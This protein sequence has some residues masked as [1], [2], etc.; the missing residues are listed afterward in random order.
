MKATLL[1]F[2]ALGATAAACAL[3]P[4]ILPGTVISGFSPDN[5]VAVSEYYGSVFIF[6]LAQ[7][8]ADPKIYTESAD[9][10][11]S[12]TTG[13]GNF[14]SNNY[15]CGHRGAGGSS[16][17]R[18]GAA[19]PLNGRWVSVNGAQ[20]NDYG[21]GL[22]NG[23]TADSHRFCGS[24]ATGVQF[25]I[26][27]A[28]QMLAPCIWEIEGNT[29]NRKILPFPAGD[30]CGL[31]PQYVTALCISDD[32]NTVMGQVRSNNGM[33]NEYIFYTRDENGEWS[34]KMPFKSLVNP[35]NRPWPTYPGDDAPVIPSQESYM[36]PEQIEA[37]TTALNAWREDDGVNVETMPNY[38]DYMY[39]DSIE[40]YNRAA[41]ESNRWQLSYEDY[42]NADLQIRQESTSFVFNQG[43]M[44][45]NGRYMV[46]SSESGYYDEYAQWHGVYKP[47]LYDIQEDRILVDDGPS[48]LVTGVSD[49]GDIIGYERTADI[50]FGYVLPAGETEWVPLEKW[51]VDRNPELAQ[52]V[53]DN[54]RH[55]IQV[56]IDEEEDLTEF[57]DMYITG[58]PFIS[59]DWTTLSTVAYFFWDDAPAGY[60][61]DYC[62]SILP[63]GP[64]S[65]IEEVEAVEPE[66]NKD[67]PV[68]NLQ[69]VR[70]A[71]PS[72]PGLYISA[73]RKHLVR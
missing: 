73:G 12:Y 36:T 24:V 53:E 48:I 41:E 39:P 9:G 54:W 51:V 10:S 13:M 55:E 21:M 28:G 58:M 4:H 2:L 14:I 64:V 22:V 62:S 38:A 7:P 70:V 29:I 47:F 60:R 27:V 67:A 61:N 59:R 23:V 42:A 5:R 20:S 6:D 25:G 33:F 35:N 45:P 3:E 50:E 69:G 57:V 11:V 66:V 65:S 31:T 52:W 46:T 1:S 63:L 17:Y 72:R 26:D 19:G 16:V 68:Y 32:G 30:Y 40:A 44:S 15:V 18:W 34:Y 8:E 37:F 71:N 49:R 56:V 43:A